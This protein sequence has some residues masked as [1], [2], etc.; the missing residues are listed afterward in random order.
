MKG[1]K[2]SATIDKIMQ[3]NN[4]DPEK[5]MDLLDSLCEKMTSSDLPL[6]FEDLSQRYKLQYL[7]ELYADLFINFVYDRELKNE[8]YNIFVQ[9]NR[10]T[11]EKFCSMFD[12]IYL[13][14]KKMNE[15]EGFA[16]LNDAENPFK[17]IS[18]FYQKVKN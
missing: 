8:L 11:K 5:A 17:V 3:L 4:I 10:E 13:N 1:A 12:N 9:Q 7:D 6:L 18:E 14:F 2:I 15:D 16:D